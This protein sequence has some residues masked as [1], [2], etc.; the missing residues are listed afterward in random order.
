MCKFITNFLKKIRNFQFLNFTQINNIAIISINYTNL[1]MFYINSL[2][3][4]LLIVKKEKK[5]KRWYY[6]KNDETKNSKVCFHKF[7]KIK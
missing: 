6:I 1:N 2:T 4:N 7:L 3:K 5:Y